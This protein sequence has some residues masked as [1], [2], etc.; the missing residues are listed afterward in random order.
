MCCETSVGKAL[1]RLDILARRAIT[2]SGP[3]PFQGE[4]TGTHG[5]IIHFLLLH[6]GETVY[7][8][9][10]EREFGITRSTASRVLG[11][12]EERNLVRRR[13]VAHDARLKQ[14]VLTDKARACDQELRSRAEA[15][16]KRMLSGF[17]REET[18][19]LMSYLSRMQKNLSEKT[20]RIQEETL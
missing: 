13:G 8:K 9:D 18:E 16:E 15:M 3:P 11:L 6:D 4:V 19:R 12:M 20:S 1:H 17:T 10:L 14:V 2:Q 5:H 7:Q